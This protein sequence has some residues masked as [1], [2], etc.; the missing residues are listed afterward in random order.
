MVEQV[1]ITY[2]Y[3]TLKQFLA[4]QHSE[5]LHLLWKCWSMHLSHLWVIPVQD[6]KLCFACCYHWVMFLVFCLP[7]TLYRH[8]DTDWLWCTLSSSRG[9]NTSASVSHNYWGQ[10]LHF[11]IWGPILNKCIKERHPMWKQCKTGHKLA[12]LTNKKSH[13]TLPLVPNRW[14]F[15]LQQWL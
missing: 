12:L 11:S 8:Q 1:N 13:M 9:C 6:I 14:P 10:I 2:Y 15:R 7:G 3:H 5:G 4:T